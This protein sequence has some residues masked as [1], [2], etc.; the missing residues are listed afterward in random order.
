MKTNL[1]VHVSICSNIIQSFLFKWWGSS[2]KEIC[3]KQ[4]QKR[5]RRWRMSKFLFTYFSCMSMAG[6]KGGGNKVPLW[7]CIQECLTYW[8]LSNILSMFECLQYYSAQTVFH[9]FNPCCF[10]VCSAARG[11]IN[12]ILYESEK[13]SGRKFSKSSWWF[14]DHSC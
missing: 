12:H 9:S 10:L 1:A 7:L 3:M 4:I 5:F 14:L 13:M 2:S 6:Y 11:L 8:P